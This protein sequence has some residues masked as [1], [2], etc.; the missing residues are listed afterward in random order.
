MVSNFWFFNVVVRFRPL[1]T[2][3][4]VL[5]DVRFAVQLRM[6][7]ILA[8]GTKGHGSRAFLRYCAHFNSDILLAMDSR[9]CVSLSVVV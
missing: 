5:H 3:I 2:C 4:H 6:A 7:L 1:E 8:M 9:A